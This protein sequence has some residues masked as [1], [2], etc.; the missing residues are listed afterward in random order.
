[1]NAA[2]LAVPSPRAEA[3]GLLAV[4]ALGLAVLGLSAI[5]YYGGDDREYFLAAH[6]WLVDFPPLGRTHWSLRYPIVLPLALYQKLVGINEWAMMLVN[7][8]YGTGVLAITYAVTRR[9][10]GPLAALLCLA[11]LASNP[12]FAVGVVCLLSDVPEL[13]FVAASMGLYLWNFQLRAEPDLRLSILAG[14]CIGLAFMVRETSVV[15]VC[16]LFGAVLVHRAFRHFLCMGFFGFAPVTFAAMAYQWYL[17]GNPLYRLGVSSRHDSIDR[18]NLIASV[19]STGDFID[20]NGTISVNVLFDPLILLLANHKIGLIFWLLLGALL[21]LRLHPAVLTPLQRRIVLIL[22]L[23]L[24]AWT[25]FIAL[26]GSILWL[27]ARYLLVPIWLACM[28]ASAVAAEAFGMRGRW[29]QAAAAALLLVFGTNLALLALEHKEPMVTERRL[30]EFI[31]GDPSQRRVYSDAATARNTNLLLMFSGLP[32][33]I[34]ARPEP[35]SFAAGDQPRAG[36]LFVASSKYLRKCRESGAG[37]N[38]AQC[39]R[40][41][42]GDRYDPAAWPKVS[43]WA[44]E[45][46]FVLQTLDRLGVLRFVPYGIARRLMRPDDRMTVYQ[47]AP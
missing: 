45:L 46:P 10:F 23:A 34:L 11:I 3:L 20:W 15:M 8:V 47:I 40:A 2:T 19:A 13:F 18:A 28:V 14:L 39:I 31:A 35:G 21:L 33:R 32:T 41:L 6:Q 38:E 24:L 17:S 12:V 1:M 36:D 7:L 5:G 42:L 25:L 37:T 44:F 16:F 43:G 26:A 4:A 29:A 27:V 30:A 9:I 22:V